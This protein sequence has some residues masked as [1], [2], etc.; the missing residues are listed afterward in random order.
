MEIRCEKSGDE[1]AINELTAK[2]FEPIEYSDGSEPAIIRKLRADGD[3]SLSL[4][5][6][7]ANKIVG[8]IAFS[9][10]VIDGVDSH[11]F[12]LGP[13]SVAIEHQGTGIGSKLINQGLDEIKDSGARVCVLIGD[14]AYYSRFGFKN[15]GRVTYGEVPQEFVLWL[16]LNGSTPNGEIKYRPAFGGG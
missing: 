3:L 13:V 5:A 9:K 2:A 12:G 8:H 6:V 4:V 15:D 1:V 10:V 11:W 7:S 14:P 16:S